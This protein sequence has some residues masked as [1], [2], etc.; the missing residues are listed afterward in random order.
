MSDYHKIVIFDGVCSFCNGAVAFVIRRDRR[1][2]FK[3]AP[4][5]SDAG[6]SLLQQHGLE[7]LADETFVLVDGETFLLRTDAALAI[8]AELTIPWRWLALFK[9]FP[10]GFRDFFYRQFA[11]HR[12]RLFGRRDECMVPTSEWRD[13]FLDGKSVEGID[14]M[15]KD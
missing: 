13:R 6:R 11:R 5:Q 8:A 4:T 10:Q 1:S 15:L 12:Y 14:S 9:V 2:L 7:S 3:F